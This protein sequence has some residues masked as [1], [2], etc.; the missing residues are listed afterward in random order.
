MTSVDYDDPKVQAQWL[1]EQHDSVERYLQ[2]QGLP[3]EPR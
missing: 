3:E 2:E 1:S